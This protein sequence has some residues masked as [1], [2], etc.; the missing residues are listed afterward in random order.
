MEG[1]QCDTV[2]CVFLYDCVQYDN[3]EGRFEQILY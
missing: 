2:T 3:S 1:Q